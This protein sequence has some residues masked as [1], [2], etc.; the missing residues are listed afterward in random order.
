MSATARTSSARSR[1]VTR[2]MP[3]PVCG[4]SDWCR[5]A[6][7]DSYVICNR[8]SSE[9]P[10]SGGGGGW[11]HR[12]GPGVARAAEPV[13]LPIRPGAASAQTQHAASR[14]LLS[15]CPLGQSH[16][17][18]LIG[19]GMAPDRIAAH[20]YGT[21][22]LR[23]RSAICRAMRDAGIA[24][25]GV[26]G[27]SIK[28]GDRGDY[29]TVAGSPGLIF[30]VLGRSGLIRGCRIRPDDPRQGGK[31]IWL[32]S[33]DRPGGAPSGAHCHIAIPPR[34]TDPRSL[35]ITEGEL[36]A[37]IA[38][39]RLGARVISVPGVGA[40]LKALPDVLDLLPGGGRVVVAL[41]SDWHDKPAVLGAIWG[42]VQSCRA[43]GYRVDVASWDASSKGLDLNQASPQ[44]D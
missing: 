33:G 20:G 40:W 13:I 14:R 4:G 23:G 32:S 3:C 37:A 15:L 26:P 17:R 35:W 29:W 36:K 2:R 38:A 10:A 21:L 27:F 9:R 1:R 5:V 41:D 7:D 16:R 18:D 24:L 28:S 42:L 44:A 22:P 39:D 25:A 6:C 19:R 8:E 43:L 12:L 30:P 34:D 11:V 31:Y